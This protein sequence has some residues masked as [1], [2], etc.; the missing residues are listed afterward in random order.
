MHYR[1]LI[2]CFLFSTLGLAQ[3]DAG[4]GYTIT[5]ATQDT[6][7]GAFQP[8]AASVLDGSAQLVSNFVLDFSDEVPEAAR[9]SMRFAADI[10]GRYLRS[11]V[12]IRVD[13]DWQDRGNRRLLASAGPGTLV[14][15]FPGA[16]PNTWYAIALAEAIAGQN[17]ND[18]RADINVTANS[19]A[20]WYFGTD[21]NPPRNR[22]DLVSVFLH[23]LGHG[24]GFL[25]SADTISPTEL[26]IGFSGRFIVYDLGI[27]TEDGDELTDESL[28]GNPSPDLLE[29]AL[30][31]SLVFDG[32][33]AN[34]ANGGRRVPL[35][36][37]GAFDAGSSIS[38]LDERT[39]RPGTENALM[40]PFLAAGEA[41]HDPGPITLGLFQDLGWE[42][43][44]DLVAVR[45][46]DRPAPVRL[47]PN[48]ARDRVNIG[49][50]LP[51]G[52]VNFQLT[53]AYGRLQLEGSLPETGGGRALNTGALTPG[54]YQLLLRQGDRYYGGRLLIL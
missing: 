8:A 41:V 40:T 27:E 18:Q 36:A 47:Y 31:N 53:D 16:V 33:N 43:N 13:V 42:V 34:A 15:D 49:A 45:T 50:D 7:F 26:G 1:Y 4:F 19:T 12:T 44:F 38:H 29:A 46:T 3:T 54:V 24:L 10:W 22:I 28:F 39:Y 30:S 11:D 21:G 14:R 9:E 23:E 52:P 48:P 2:C 35:F 37:P 20:N 17:F 32:F 5:C 6:A 51:A 25:S